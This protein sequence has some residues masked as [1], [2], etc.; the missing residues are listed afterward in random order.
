MSAVA[1]HPSASILIV[2]DESALR[3]TTAI[4]LELEGY[5]VRA[6]ATMAGAE[7]WLAREQFDILVL[8]RGLPDGDA[9]TWLKARHA[10]LRHKGIIITSARGDNDDRVAGIRAGADIYL[11]K[12]VLL[13]ELSS[14]IHNL[15]R[16]IDD[17][18]QGIWQ[19]HRTRWLIESPEGVEV[20]L[21]H[22][23]HVFLSSLAAIPGHPVSR[24]ELILLLGQKPAHYDVRRM[25]ML[26]RRLRAK[27]ED[28]LGHPLPVQTAHRQGYAFIAPITLV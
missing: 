15:L 2:E 4:Y 8:D 1:S 13:E 10:A 6:V 3:D 25:D 18:R 12:P 9:L 17:R 14:L 22:S 5:I 28:A 21:T 27:C 11:V 16:R 7:Q 23:E 19:L 26:V 20:R 24:E